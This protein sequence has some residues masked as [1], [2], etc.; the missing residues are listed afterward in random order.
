[1]DKKQT[2]IL[3]IVGVVFFLVGVSAGVVIQSQNKIQVQ[4]NTAITGLSSRV[5]TSITAYGEIQK[6]EG[7]KITL[8]NLGQEMPVLMAE[9]AKVYKFVAQKGETSLSQQPAEFGEI[10]VGDNVNIIMKLQ[11]NGEMQGS[12]IVILPKN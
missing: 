8:S 2:I 10:K 4:K 9:S 7:K 1:M 12:S 6:I 5:I 11:K 3:I